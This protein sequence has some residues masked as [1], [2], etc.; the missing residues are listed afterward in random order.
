MGKISVNTVIGPVWIE[1]QHER[2]VRI[3]WRRACEEASDSAVLQEARKQIQAYFDDRLTEF[4]LPL[5]PE[6]SPFQRRVW[7]A[8]RKIPH[9]KTWTY[10]ELAERVNTGPRAVG[11]ACGANP[12]PIIIPCHRVIAANSGGGYSGRGGM[13]TKFALLELESSKARFL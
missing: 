7:S 10:S 12:I 1:E 4:D 2:I 11:G 3:G 5:A 8:M 13:K 6:G 9:G